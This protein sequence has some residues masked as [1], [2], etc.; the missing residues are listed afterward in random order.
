MRIELADDTAR[1]PL[2]DPIEFK[3]TLQSDFSRPRIRPILDFLEYEKTK[4]EH[5]AQSDNGDI[6]NID[7]L[8]IRHDS[9]EPDTIIYTDNDDIQA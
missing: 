8:I 2:K 4:S 1:I 5:E 7:E 6:E 9:E 3:R